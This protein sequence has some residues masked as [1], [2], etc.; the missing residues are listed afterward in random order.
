MLVS[1]SSITQIKGCN[2]QLHVDQ[3]SKNILT[4]VLSEILILKVLRQY[5]ILPI[6][7]TIIN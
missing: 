2:T 7:K 1:N 6:S 3:V 4:A 5:K